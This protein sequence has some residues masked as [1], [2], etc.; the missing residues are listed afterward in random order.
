[1]MNKFRFGLGGMG[2]GG[3]WYLPLIKGQRELRDPPSRPC[4]PQL[5]G[6][7]A[8]VMETNCTVLLL[9]EDV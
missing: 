8:G 7:S 3:S 1:M 2:V 4:T 5:V 9:T 6:F